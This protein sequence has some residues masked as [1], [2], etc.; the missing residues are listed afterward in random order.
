MPWAGLWP[1][2]KECR[3]FGWYSEKGWV[4]CAKEEPGAQ[5]NL[6]RLVEEARW[7]RAE[8]RWVQR[9]AG[10]TVPRRS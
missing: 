3:E 4:P 2:V 7:D 6:S 10:L 8:K 9:E 1:G 5:E